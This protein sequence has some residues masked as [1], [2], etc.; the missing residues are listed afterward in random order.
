MGEE[1]KCITRGVEFNDVHFR[2]AT[3]KQ[4]LVLQG[5]NLRGKSRQEVTLVGISGRRKLTTRPSIE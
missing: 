2:Y 5:L 1:V 3:R 4:V